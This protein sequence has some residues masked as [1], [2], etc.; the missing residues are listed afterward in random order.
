MKRLKMIVAAMLGAMLMALPAWAATTATVTVNGQITGSPWG[1]Q[2]IAPPPFT[3]SS[4]IGQTSSTTLTTITSSYSITIP[5]G[6]TAVLL[7]VPSGNTAEI[8]IFAT[9]AACGTCRGIDMA[10]NFRWAFI[11]LDTAATLAASAS[12]ASTVLTHTFF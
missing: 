8:S 7:T 2:L 1:S 11:P 6:A 9:T 12:V 5:S 10:A 4:A 3:A